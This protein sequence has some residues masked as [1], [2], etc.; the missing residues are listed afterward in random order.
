M[1]R[2]DL[3]PRIAK[4]PRASL[5]TFLLDRSGSMAMIKSQTIE[6][7]NAYL[8]TLKAD[9]EARIDFTLITF[10]S[11]SVDKVHIAVPIA[12]VPYLDNASYQPRAETPL[13]DAAVETIHAVSALLSHRKERTKVV[14]NIQTDGMENKSHDHTWEELHGLVTRKQAHGWQFNFMGVG[15]EAYHQG[16]RMGIAHN[17]TVAYNP[18]EFAS[19][20]A[21]FEA[22]ASNAVNYASG[23][24]AGTAYTTLQKRNA[25]DRFG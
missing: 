5:V 3:I 24:S 2:I 9:K 22:S 6:G 17:N 15:I 1:N 20:R 21:V 19:T 14:I 11:V 10:D 7:F 18:N 12:R 25:G 23:N 16:M 8:A 4:P 13:I